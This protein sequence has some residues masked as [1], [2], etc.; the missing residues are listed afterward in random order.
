MASYR[1]MHRVTGAVLGGYIVLSATQAE[2]DTANQRLHQTGS[3]YR[4][5]IDLHPPK[6]SVQAA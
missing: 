3:A 5:V 1:L 2:I 6:Q 4:Y